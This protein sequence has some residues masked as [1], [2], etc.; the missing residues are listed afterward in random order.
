MKRQV[1]VIHGA[2]TYDT[3]EEYLKSLR[4]FKIDLDYF[5]K[6]K[7]KKCLQQKLGD[8][9]DVILPEMPNSFNAKYV[10]WKIWF[11]KIAPLL[12]DGVVLLG[13][14]QGGIF[15]AKYLSEN[16]MPN[17]ISATLLV[18]PPF[19]DADSEYS[20]ADFDLPE[21]LDKLAKQGGRIVIYHSKDDPV[22]PFKDLAKYQK[23]LPSAEAKVFEDRGHF[24]Q[25]EFPEILADIAG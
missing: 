21:S 22:V 5:R 24:N 3:Y 15:L 7:W 14:S 1:V 11:D 25:E 20:I 4:E 16:D 9:F 23:A 18:A 10:E 8:D 17:K 6:K 2:D 12:D 13:H 19:D